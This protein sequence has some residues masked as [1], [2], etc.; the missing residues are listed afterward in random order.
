PR[1]SRGDCAAGDAARDRTPEQ[2]RQCGQPPGPERL[3]RGGEGLPGSHPPHSDRRE[4]LPPTRRRVAER[5]RHRGRGCRVPEVPRARPG[6]CKRTA[7]QAAAQDPQGPAES[8]FLVAAERLSSTCWNDPRGQMNFDIKTEE[9]S[10]DAYVI[11]L[12]GEVDL[13]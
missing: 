12:T 10:N 13:Y 11:A 1:A 7:R 3:P 6:R 8:R 9:L 4:R 5:E 2:P